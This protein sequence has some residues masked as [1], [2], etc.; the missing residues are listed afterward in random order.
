MRTIAVIL[1]LLA[2][3][4]SDTSSSGSADAGADTA[5]DVARLCEP[6]SRQCKD[7][8]TSQVC[9]ADG[10]SYADEPCADDL[11]CNDFTGECA[12]EICVP[13]GFEGC[14]DLGLMRYCNESGTQIVEANCPG[15]APCENNACAA[16]ECVPGEVRCI[17]NDQLEVCNDAGARVPGAR[18]PV[19]TECFNGS[20]EE[21]CELNKKISSY[22][23]CEYWSV[24][25]DNYDDALSQPHAIVVSNVNESIA[26]KVE[27]TLG[28]SGSKLTTG[29]DGQPFDLTI[30]PGEAAIYAI[31][32]GFDHSGTRVLKDKAIRV[33]ANIPIIAYQFNPLNNV[34][35]YSNDGTLL[36]PTNALGNEY[37]G[38]SWPYRQGPNLRGFL[39]IVNSSGQ[40]NRVT[41]TPTAEV[42]AGPDI[43]AIAAGTERT[44]DLAPGESL[45]LTVSGIEFDAAREFGCLQDTQGPPPNVSPCPD[46][47]G[48]RI[49]GEQPLTVFGGHQC[50][51]VVQ[52]VDR[53]DHMETILFPVSTWGKNYIG[54]KFSP[55]AGEITPEPDVW[56]V[57][58]AEDNTQI[59]TIPPIDG[60]HGKRIDSGQWLQFESTQT[61]ILGAS[62][63]VTLAQ[64][65]VGSNWFGIPRICNEGIDAA[66]PTGI[67]DPAMAAA[68]PVDQYRRDYLLLTPKDY[69][70]DFL[71]IAAPAGREVRI[72]GVPIPRDL[73]KPVGNGSYETA[74]VPVEDGF[75]KVTSDVPFG[76]LSYGYDCHVSY[77]YPGGLNLEQIS[78]RP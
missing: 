59:Q 4:S 77:A 74:V 10:Q 61:F 76:V 62:K 17:D 34:D 5:A 27:L 65:M 14:T 57:V 67:G 2:G 58:A 23:G 12:S 21:L 72:D 78:A 47:T 18:C 68:V 42:L 56:R 6:D 3:C 52:G 49:V 55:R 63:P 71:N 64:Y 20:C 37:W 16:P 9:A 54:T 38:I 11:R 15:N 33:T 53:C 40:P 30:G 51:N 41:I 29:A 22:I 26:A 69:D 48:T 32:T 24:D 31:P 75:H 36:L 13:G 73:F 7:L 8:V 43:P 44:I 46:L 35:V 1:T 39:T 25:L 60:I 45:N 66:N 50:A 19:G 70:L 28:E